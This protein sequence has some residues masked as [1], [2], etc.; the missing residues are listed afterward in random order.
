MGD[1]VFT[2]SFDGTFDVTAGTTTSG[3]TLPSQVQPVVASLASGARLNPRSSTATPPLISPRPRASLGLVQTMPTPVILAGK[4]YLP[5]IYGTI[6]VTGNAHAGVGHLRGFPDPD[7][8]WDGTEWTVPPPAAPAGA[9]F[10]RWTVRDLPNPGT[11][12]GGRYLLGHR[13]TN[14]GTDTLPA[15]AEQWDSSPGSDFDIPWQSAWPFKPVVQPH[16]HYGPDGDVHTIGAGITFHTHR[17]GHMWADMGS[18]L[19][20]PFTMLFVGVMLDFPSKSYLNYIFDAGFDPDTAVTTAQRTSIY[21]LGASGNITLS[22]AEGYRNALRVGTNQVQMFNDPTPTT[23]LV[24]VPFTSTLKPKMIAMVVNGASSMLA[25]FDN[26]RRLHRPISLA[27]H[28]AQR[29]WV[30]GRANGIISVA[31]SCNA[32]AFEIRAWDKALT[33]AHLEAQ[34]AQLR[35]TWDFAGYDRQI[36]NNARAQS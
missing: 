9:N 5:K 11:V 3:L 6:G 31:R 25:V 28:G 14:D 23:R 34:F 12:T 36:L 35:S 18:L 20:P 4:P 1:H 30:L 21:R 22:E 32:V 16:V 29:L 27:S 13:V 33:L 2:G 24:R 15:G 8:V 7:P 19:T 26:S 17:V 10:V